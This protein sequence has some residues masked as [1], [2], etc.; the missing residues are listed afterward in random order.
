MK[1]TDAELLKLLLE[2]DEM[3]ALLREPAAVDRSPSIVGN[4]KELPQ[5]SERVTTKIPIAPTVP[6][7]P[8]SSIKAEQMVPD[9]DYIP[10]LTRYA[11]AKKPDLE[12]EKEFDA[13]A[14]QYVKGSVIQTDLS[15]LMNWYKANYGKDLGY[16]KPKGLD[17]IIGNEAKLRKLAS[18]YGVNPT[19]MAKFL[20][21]NMVGNSYTIGATQPQGGGEKIIERINKEPTEKGSGGLSD[22][23]IQN[24]LE[25]ISKRLEPLPEMR[26]AITTLSPY[27]TTGGDIPGY[28]ATGLAPDAW[29]SDQG[30]S[31]RQAFRTLANAKVKMRTGAQASRQEMDRI[32]GEWGIG[33][34]KSDKDLRLGIK[35]AI[36]DV[37]SQA[38][39]VSSGYLP[40]VKK[41]FSEQNGYGPDEFLQEF[42]SEAV[43]KKMPAGNSELEK[44]KK[45]LEEINKKLEKK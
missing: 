1:L 25:A 41:A 32:M 22:A 2:N 26:N 16:E 7:T 28:G 24:K 44:K 36:Q 15:P 27:L 31:V 19:D 17:E 3:S 14:D 11:Q 38:K 34:L 40:E 37:Y 5:Y 10:F 21:A 29:V 20:Q 13:L 23:Q 30:S 4:V 42:G 9:S 18:E 35:K 12:K 6:G 45:E 8:S 43:T 39:Q 33:S